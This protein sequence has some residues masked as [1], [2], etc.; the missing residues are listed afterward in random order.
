MEYSSSGK[1]SI[2]KND[3]FLRYIPIGKYSVEFKMG[4]N[5]HSTKTY[6]LA[7]EYLTIKRGETMSLNSAFDFE[8]KK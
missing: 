3:A 2:A 4:P 6:V 7:D 5:A 8:E 1:G